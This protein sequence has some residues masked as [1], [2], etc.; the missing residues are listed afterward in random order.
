MKNRD[1]K[2]TSLTISL[3]A[4]ILALV[5]PAVAGC[6]TCEGGACAIPASETGKALSKTNECGGPGCAAKCSAAKAA[7]GTPD[8]DATAVIST[9]SLKT[10]LDARTGKHDDGRR[11]AGW[12]EAGHEV[13]ETKQ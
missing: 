8:K 1:N 11:I 3:T 2:K 10:L 5:L 7:T 6:K 12:A 13:K 9:T 4:L